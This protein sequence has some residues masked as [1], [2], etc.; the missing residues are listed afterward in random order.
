MAI[1]FFPDQ[2]IF[3]DAISEAFAAGNRNV[4][5]VAPT[6]S[7]KTVVAAHKIRERKGVTCAIAHR[8]ELVS[9]L[10]VALAREEVRHTIIG[11]GNL[12]KLCV[13]LHIQK[14]G[15]SYFSPDARC[16]VAGVDTLLRRKE[17]LRRWGESVEF[18]FQDE[19]HHVQ[20]N[21]K[22]GKS[23]EL[24]PNACGL[25]FT[26]TPKRSDGGGLARW[27]DGVFDEL[28]EGAPMRWLINNGRLSD[29]TI[30]APP[31]N[32][33]LSN[34]PIGANGDFIL[35][36]A[37][38]AL[39]K[40]TVYGDVV[41]HYLR[42]AEGK[43]GVTFA[44]TVKDAEKIAARFSDAGVP[45]VVIHAGTPGKDRYN[46]LRAY[47]RREILQLVNVDIFGEGFDLPAIEVCSFARPTA[48]WALFVQQF[49][50]ALRV[51]P[52]KIRAIIIDHVGNVMRHNG[53]P[54]RPILHTLERAE[55]RA[56]SEP[57]LYKVCA[58]PVCNKVYNRFMKT[59]PYC[60]AAPVPVLRS[61][62][63][64]VDGDLTE[65]DPATLAALRREIDKIDMPAD[66]YR[67]DLL[68][69][70]CPIDGIE[71]NIRLH[72]KHQ[73]AQAKLRAMIALWG[74]AQRDLGRLDAESY[75]LFWLL[76]GVDVM[77]AQALKSNEA[78]VLTDRIKNNL[79][80][81]GV[82]I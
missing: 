51:M 16:A 81:E 2:Q 63:E 56:P 6:G 60:G 28:V 78:D 24:F 7:G 41:D 64:Y 69:R 50:R 27:N 68:A 21:N 13:N 38:A 55:K 59:C 77:T 67:T 80:E 71:R 70:H 82:Q 10:S 32:L 26:A 12:I 37:A 49:G 5:A 79:M 74:G 48:S 25:G 76:F 4:L 43:L 34:V 57:Q 11:P 17:R 66:Q 36:K 47:E 39:E 9:Q 8:Q 58:N 52:G 46:Y 44:P 14:I 72:A 33:N 45:A 22:W 31:S 73:A 62:P 65:L 35:E 54:D 1:T 53:P 40:S 18:W 29:Y 3:S 19:A 15:K 30:Y 75:R 20:K 42:I 23:L 61:G